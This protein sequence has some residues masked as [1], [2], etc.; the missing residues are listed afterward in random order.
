MDTALQIP[1]NHWEE[2]VINHTQPLKL[3][4]N[5][6]T[7]SSIP[8]P[9]EF[10]YQNSN[11][12]PRIDSKMPRSQNQGFDYGAFDIGVGLKLGQNPIKR[13]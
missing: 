9:T 6:I 1:S 3:V 12:Y 13:I 4:I 7:T 10:K 11:T 8:L 2:Y 5:L